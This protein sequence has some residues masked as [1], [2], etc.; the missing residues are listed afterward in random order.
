MLKK[1]QTKRGV[2]VTFEVDYLPDAEQI[3][4]AGDWNDWELVPMKKYKNG[5]HKALVRLEKGQEYQF[6]YRIDGARWENEWEADGY[7]PNEH[8]ADNSLVVC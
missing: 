3:E 5:K 4:I 8:G 1:K 6:R 7:V 2:S